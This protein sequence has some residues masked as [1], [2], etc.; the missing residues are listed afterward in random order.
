MVSVGQHPN[1]ELLTCSEVIEVSGHVGDFNVKVKRRPRY[2]REEDCTG[3]GECAK[4]CPVYVDDEFELG[5]TKRRAIYRYFAQSVPNAYAITKRGTAPCKHA[6][7]ASTSAQGYIALTAEGRFQ[8]ALEVSRRANPFTSV[9][10]RICYHPCEDAC[11]RNL[12]DE[13]ISI[14]GIKRFLADY[15]AEH[16]DLPVEPVEVTRAEKIAV[17]GAGPAGLTA[18]HDLARL[19]Y[20]VTVYEAQPK[21]GGML[22]YGIPA[23]RLP[24]KILDQ[25]IE[26]IVALGVDIRTNSP[27]DDVDLLAEKYDAVFIAIGAHKDVRMG[28]EGEDLPGVY[29]AVEFLRRINAGEKLDVGRKVIVVGGGNTA[30]D[31][32]RTSRRLGAEVSIIYRRSRAEMPAH[33]F[34]VLAAEEEGVALQFLASPVRIMERDGGPG[35]VVECIRMRLGEPDAS[36]RRRPIPIEGS[37]FLVEADTVILAIGQLPDLSLLPDDVEVT[38]RSTIV[39]DEETQATSRPGL[40][41]G[42]DVA[43]GPRNA[44][45]AIAAGHRAAQSIHR[46]LCGEEVEFLPKKDESRVVR[47]SE[48]EIAAGLAEGTIQRQARARMPCLPPEERVK[49]FAEVELGLTEEQAVAEAKR[50]LACGI[51]SECM[52]CVEVCGPKCIDHNMKEEIVELNVGAIILATGFTTFDCTR[53]P[54]YGYGL[55]NVLTSIEFERMCHSTGPTGGAVV[56]KDG[57]PPKSVAILH[58]VGSRDE[59]YNRYCSRVCCMYSV[60]NAHMVR[61]RTGAKVY[62]IYRD[63]RTFGKGYEEFFN[64]VAE[65]GII[66]IR[67]NK[68]VRVTQRNGRLLVTALDLLKGE[69]VELEVDMVILGNGLEPHP[70]AAKVAEIFGIE[71]DSNGFFQDVHPKLAS[72]ETKRRGIFIAGACQGPKDIPDAVAQGGAAAAAVLSLIDQGTLPLPHFTSFIREEL[73]GACHTCVSVCPYQAIRMVSAN[74]TGREVARIDEA[75]CHGCGTCVAACPTGAA[76][77]RTYTDRQILAEVEG[78]LWPVS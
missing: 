20:A 58:C 29:P 48:E 67:S 77:Q 31:A 32:A 50:C 1:I 3:C 37:E 59:N 6:C 78:A 19:G 73:C 33:E 47:L 57:T 40:F 39:V 38:R 8:E 46:Y 34:E 27:V 45:E 36:G 75:L 64:R 10:G 4:V 43:T 16:G 68:D 72:V 26:R 13:P 52:A 23:Y 53:A 56:L 17:V 41:A 49:S 62:E 2:V 65:E 15:A 44:I 63:M 25:E 5:K 76:T 14:R 24:E 9:C 74:G 18:A 35:L 42:G 55:D 70:D 11:S 71:Q 51:C 28:I 12:V 69:T 21:A 61:E 30:I 22:R 7:P 66:L 54:Q 60:K